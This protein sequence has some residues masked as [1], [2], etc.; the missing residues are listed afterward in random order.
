[1]D[2][3][4]IIFFI[5]FVSFL[6]LRRRPPDPPKSAGERTTPPFMGVATMG[7]AEG[8]LGW[9]TAAAGICLFTG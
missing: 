5:F 1:L 8:A 7:E 3:V 9:T 4:R 6:L 2:S